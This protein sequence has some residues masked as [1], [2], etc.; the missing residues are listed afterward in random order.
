MLYIVTLT[1]L[2]KKWD[3]KKYDGTLLRQMI[4]KKIFFLIKTIYVFSKEK[5]TVE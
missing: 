5:V 1:K 3:L 4:P 2:L